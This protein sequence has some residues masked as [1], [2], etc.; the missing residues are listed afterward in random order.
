MLA[1]QW[2]MGSGGPAAA[3]LNKGLGP[4]G[5][6]E[7]ACVPGLNAEIRISELGQ[8][9]HPTVGGADTF[10]LRTVAVPSAQKTMAGAR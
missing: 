5:S 8:T 9:V 6:R 3:T 4:S 10:C 2:V 1:P 7:P